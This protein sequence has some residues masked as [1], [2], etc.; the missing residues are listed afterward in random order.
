MSDTVDDQL[1]LLSCLTSCTGWAHFDQGFLSNM[2]NIQDLDTGHRY[3]RGHTNQEFWHAMS[4]RLLSNN[5]HLLSSNVSEPCRLV[6]PGH[7][8]H[9]WQMQDICEQSLLHLLWLSGVSA[10]LKH[11]Q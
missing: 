4:K 6:P 2:Y 1:L 8:K 11:C 10:L 7:N 9:P 3:I 5:K